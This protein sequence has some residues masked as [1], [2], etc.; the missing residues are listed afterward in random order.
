MTL[1]A[2]PVLSQAAILRRHSGRVAVD[3]GHRLA[4]E[5][6]AKGGEVRGYGV[7]Q[8]D[9]ISSCLRRVEQQREIWPVADRPLHWR[10]STPEELGVA[11]PAWSEA[12]HVLTRYLPG[13]RPR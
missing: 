13:T 8:G 2:N 7:T 12:P 5:E 1:R 10:R 4:I 6:H 3:V 11:A 9:F